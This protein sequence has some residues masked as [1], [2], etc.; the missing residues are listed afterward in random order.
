M[1]MLIRGLRAVLLISVFSA[2]AQTESL[3]VPG[4]YASTSANTTDNAPLG[5]ANQHIQ[6]DFAAS[7]LAA[8]NLQLGDQITAIGFRL[9]SGQASLPA[10]TV[11]DYSIWMGLGVSPG[12][13][14]STFADN[15]SGMLQVRSG[16]LNITDGQ[17]SGGTGV[18]PFGIIDLSQPYTY[19]GGNLLVEIAYSDFASGGNVDAAYPYDASLAQTAFGTGPTSSTADQG[20][21]NEAFVMAFDVIPAPEPSVF[22]FFSCGTLGFIFLSRNRSRWPSKTFFLRRG[23]S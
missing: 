15:G 2:S 13:M 9:A 23:N 14:T 8:S 4:E 5:A 20:L 22:A 11:S 6:Q 3:V 7:L 19:S 17:F 16:S 12:S 21:F 18:N 10:Q 1:K